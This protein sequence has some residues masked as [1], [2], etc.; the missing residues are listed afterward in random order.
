[1]KIIL[2]LHAPREIDR[3]INWFSGDGM[4]LRYAG[5]TSVTHRTAQHR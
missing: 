4:K 2:L 5:A 3:I 1:M